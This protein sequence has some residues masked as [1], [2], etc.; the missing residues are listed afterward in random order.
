MTRLRRET[1]TEEILKTLHQ[2][3]DILRAKGK[4][5]RASKEMKHAVVEALRD[6]VPRSKILNACSISNAKL[7][8]WEKRY[9]PKQQLNLHPHQPRILSVVD[10]IPKKAAW[11]D[12]SLKIKIGQWLFNLTQIESDEQ[13]VVL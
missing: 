3:F 7:K 8:Y 6:Q 10:S 5:S 12:A 13:K 4:H 9:Q 11:F 1:T 2:K